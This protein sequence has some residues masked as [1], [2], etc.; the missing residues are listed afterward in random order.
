MWGLCGGVGGGLDGDLKGNF[1]SPSGRRGW[2]GWNLGVE[3][4]DLERVEREGWVLGEDPVE[5]WVQDGGE[6]AEFRFVE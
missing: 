3:K 4:P 5:L 6:G 1:F 2:D